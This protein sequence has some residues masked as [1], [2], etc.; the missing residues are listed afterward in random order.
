MQQA[1]TP[2]LIRGRRLKIKYI[3]QT[4]TRPPTFQL[5]ANMAREFPDAY[6]KYLV[7]GLRETF[8][9]EGTPIRL[10]L[11]AS[12]KKPVRQEKIKYALVRFTESSWT[13]APWEVK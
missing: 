7:H 5:F 1:H 2:P 3:T 4:K 12:G 6:K 8:G 13:R 10:M 11:K 9:L